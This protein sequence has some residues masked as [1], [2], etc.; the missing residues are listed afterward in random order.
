MEAKSDDQSRR[1]S[2]SCLPM[3]KISEE[4]CQGQEIASSARR[5]LGTALDETQTLALRRVPIPFPLINRLG[6]N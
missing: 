4:T 6:P 2:E 1:C 5:L 3:N